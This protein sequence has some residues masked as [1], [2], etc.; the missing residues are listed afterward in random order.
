MTGHTVCPRC[1]ARDSFIRGYLPETCVCRV[2]LS[3]LDW[4]EIPG[5]GADCKGVPAP[6]GQPE[7]G[8]SSPSQD[9]TGGQ[10]EE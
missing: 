8:A 6:A 7:G 9:P 4:R 3:Q 5:C 10:G 2:C 1:G